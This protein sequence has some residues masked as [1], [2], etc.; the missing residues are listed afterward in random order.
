MSEPRDWGWISVHRTI[1][2]N[3][4]WEDKP[5]SKGQAWIDLLLLANHSDEKTLLGNELIHVKRGSKVTSLRK[6]SKRWGWSI[7]KVNNF[8]NLLESDNMIVVKRNTK[9]TAYTIVNYN[10]YQDEDIDKRNTKET[11]GKHAGNTKETRGKTNN[12][13]N[14]VNNDLI[15]IDKIHQDKFI[16]TWN[17]NFNV[18]INENQ[19]NQSINQLISS[20]SIDEVLSVLDKATKSDYLLGKTETNKK[21][22]TLNF[23][24]KPSNFEKIRSGKYDNHDNYDNKKSKSKKTD[25]S[26]L[27][28]RTSYEERQ[29]FYKQKLK[30]KIPIKYKK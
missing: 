19:F 29:E 11:R 10:D 17:N 8:L 6:L 18:K 3:W 28:D 25:L 4:L 2:N 22:M 23:F 14:N 12:N 15:M 26:S 24:S 5:F 27:D 21:G 7:K 13:D 20:Y 1:F 16:N 9:R 30:E